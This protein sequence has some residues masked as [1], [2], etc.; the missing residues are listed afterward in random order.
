MLSAPS[1]AAAGTGLCGMP[2]R[3]RAAGAGRPLLYFQLASE[4]KGQWNPSRRERWNP[5]VRCCPTG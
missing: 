1:G 4:Q 5:L 2:E 3:E